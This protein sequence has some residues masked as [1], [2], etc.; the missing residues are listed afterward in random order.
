L[1]H[2]VRL[3]SGASETYAKQ[4]ETT[5]DH[6]TQLYSAGPGQTKGIGGYKDYLP[7]PQNKNFNIQA[8]N[9]RGIVG[10][11]LGFTG[12]QLNTPREAEQAVGPYIPE[13]SDFDST[14]LQK[15]QSMRELSA[16]QRQNAIQTLGGEP[17]ENGVIHPVQP[18]PQNDAP[19]PNVQLSGGSKTRSEADPVLKALGQRV[20]HMLVTGAPDQQ[21]T[22]FLQQQGVNPADTNINQ[23]L[24]FRGTKD[25][26]QWMRANPGKAYPLGP[27]F[28]TKQIPLTG[29]RALFNKTAATDVGGDVA[30]GLAASANAI[31]GDR[32]GSLSG[33]PMAQTGM[34]LLRTNHP[35]SSLAGD[36]AGQ[37]STEAAAGLI[38]GGQALMASRWGR[39]GAD[40]AY[41]AYSGSGD[42]SGGDGLTGAV[43]GGLANLGGGMFGRGLQRGAG[44]AM[45]GVKNN[46]L[47]YLDNNGV[48]LTVGDI[49][50]GSNN[51][52][53][54]TIGGIEDRLAGLPGFDAVIGK[55]RQRYDAG[56]NAAAFREMAGHSG[57]TGSAGLIEGGNLQNAAY[58]FLDG[59]NIPLDAQFAGSQAGVRAALPDLPKY[60]QEIGQ[61]LNVIDKASKGGSITGRDWQSALRSTK[62]NAA[63]IAGEPFSYE[64]GNVLG[65]VQDN[66]VDLAGRQGPADAIPNLKA[67]N[68]L[69][70]QLKTLANALDNGPAQKAG[71]LFSMG[72]LDD[73]SR[74]GARNYGGQMA[75]LSGYRPFYE[76]TKAG[77]EV[78]ANLTPDSGTAGRLALIPALAAIG[79]GGGALAG[80]SDNR[81]GG[82]EMGAGYG[83]LLGAAAMGPYSKAGQKIIQKALLAD[84][85]DK[86]IRIGDYLIANPKYAGMFGSGLARDSAMY[87]G[88]PQ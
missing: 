61:G 31:S 84:R 25:F 81:G 87:P 50:R 19:P 42:D 76:L 15:I 27:E 52:V 85:P 66:L 36:I 55:A 72:R 8:N 48:P 39:R 20:G 62:Q 9:T 71:E 16:T 46:A 43:E 86:F 63:S 11:T 70:S 6:L 54:R 79:G 12:G 65:D 21:I 58:N 68:K 4:L 49:G 56:T 88:L 29:G 13:A 24:Q 45:T 3:R 69:H 7:T 32:L 53:G 30:A 73:V 80:G 34:Q 67:A 22:S 51:I 74:A 83:A 14:I 59:A 10:Q 60:G 17:D 57:A 75:S 33:D 1:A 77:K 44:R 38:P 37:A 35:L 28:Y 47:Q 64:A 18:Q 23:A 40:L 5:A 82:A 78:R 41:G 2:P 26:K